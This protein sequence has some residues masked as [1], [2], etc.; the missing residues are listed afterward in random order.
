MF[1]F[2]FFKPKEKF[3]ILEVAKDKISALLLGVDK[4]RNLSLERIW[5]EFPLKKLG[6]AQARSLGKKKIIVS[7]APELIYT[8]TFPVRIMRDSSALAHPL[9]IVELENLLA[10]A[11]GKLFNSERKNAGAHL[12]VD[13]LDAVLVNSKVTNFKVDGHTVLNPVGFG[14]RTVEGVLE[15]TF[16]TRPVFYGLRDLFNS[17]EGF[18]FTGSHL[19]GLHTLAWVESLPANLLLIGE[20][21]ASYLT[22]DRAAWGSARYFGKIGWQMKL[23]WKAVVSALQVNQPVA[24]KLY[25]AFIKKDASPAFIRS[26]HRLL[27]SEVSDFLVQV[28][29]S[30]LKGRVFLHSSA[31]IPF[32]VPRSF[33][34]V[35]FLDLPMAKVLT[36]GGFQMDFRRLPLAQKDVF[37]KLAPFFEFHCDKS[38]S[39]INNKLRRRLHWLIQE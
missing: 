4:D 13:E 2:N 28:K 36:K 10:Q 15:L 31:P 23:L 11:I 27:R 29:K 37:M 39:D 7:A 5:D 8:T 6:A 22:L 16:T 3:L 34:R 32:D 21:G 17:K 25:D 19:A 35:T 26:F 18:F 20:E 33:G 38:N 9:T 30:R 12:G 14:G 24:L 1:N